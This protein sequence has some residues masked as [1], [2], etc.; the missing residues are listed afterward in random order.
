MF[1]TGDSFDFFE[2]AVRHHDDVTDRRPLQPRKDHDLASPQRWQHAV[3][4]DPANE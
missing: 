4:D 3:T 2:S 1:L